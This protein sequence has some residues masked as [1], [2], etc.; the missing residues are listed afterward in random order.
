M[1]NGFYIISEEFENE[2]KKLKGN[3]KFGELIKV[4]DTYDL[5]FVNLTGFTINTT[6]GYIPNGGNIAKDASLSIKTDKAKNNVKAKFIIDRIYADNQIINFKIDGETIY[7]S[8]LSENRE[9]N[10]I[11]FEIPKEKWNKNKEVKIEME[12]PNARMGILHATTMTV[13]RLESFMFEDE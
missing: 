10:I 8:D 4:E 5:D 3:Y 9:Y 12:F 2:N 13:I 6:G 1:K 7:T 11:C